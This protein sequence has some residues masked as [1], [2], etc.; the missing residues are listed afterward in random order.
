ME[1]NNIIVHASRGNHAFLGQVEKQVGQVKNSLNGMG[2]V[3]LMKNGKLSVSEFDLVVATV[4][5]QINSQPIF[6]IGKTVVSSE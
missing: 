5:H 4:E 1:R 2:M 3:D 6:H